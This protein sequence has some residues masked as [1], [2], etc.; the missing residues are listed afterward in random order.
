MKKCY[1]RISRHAHSI[2]NGTE[3]W[4]NDGKNGDDDPNNSEALLVD[5]LTTGHNY[6]TYS[7]AI[8]GKRKDDICSK[9]AEMIR[10]TRKESMHIEPVTK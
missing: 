7:G 6:D 3:H 4:K 9:I 2:Q 5:W 8:N 10:L 1:L